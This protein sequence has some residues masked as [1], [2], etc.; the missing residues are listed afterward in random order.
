MP[1]FLAQINNYTVTVTRPK[2]RRFDMATRNRCKKKENEIVISY[3]LHDNKVDVHW[4]T[5][6]FG[7]KF[8]QNVRSYKA[9][10]F[11]GRFRQQPSQLEIIILLNLR[12][13]AE[14]SGKSWRGHC[15]FLFM[16]RLPTKIICPSLCYVK[17]KI[18][19]L[20]SLLKLIMKIFG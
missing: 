9:P 15:F 18:E 6:K 20:L 11:Y 14:L 4:W 2:E 1:R 5:L 12:Y 19:V 10:N 17:Q 13:P 7:S 16:L 3:P 8:P